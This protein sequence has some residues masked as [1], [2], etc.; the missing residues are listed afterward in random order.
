MSRGHSPQHQDEDSG[1][2]LYH[3]PETRETE[4]LVDEHRRG[5]PD[6]QADVMRLM[7]E[8]ARAS[9][10]FV[11]RSALQ[12]CRQTQDRGA[13]SDES[14]LALK[15]LADV[16][17]RQ[18]EVLGYFQTARQTGS[19]DIHVTTS[20]GLTRIEMR[21]HGDLVTVAELAEQDGEAL[22]ATIILSMCDVTE[23][24]FFPMRKQDGRVAAKFLKKVGLFGARYSHTP[25]A[26]G[27]HF[28]MR[29]INDD[30]DRV[31]SLT[32]L[33]FLP[34]QIT[35]IQRILRLP[36]GMVIL[37]G[38]TGSG[39]STTLRSFSRIWLERTGFLKRLLTVEDPPEGRVAGAIQT[40]IICDKADEA[41][42]RRAWERALSSALRLD[43]D[44][45]MPGELRD[46]I[47]ILAGIFAAQTGHLV[48]S[49]L[50]T[51]SALSIPERMITMG[52]EAGLILDA[53]LM[54]GLI[55]QRLVKTLCPHCKVPWVQKVTS[56]SDEQRRYLEKYCHEPGLCRPEDL[57]FR[58]PE[59][60][61]H[62][63][64][65][66]VLNGRTVATVGHGVTGRSVVAEVI[67][68]DARL[69][70]LLKT[71][72]K[73][74]ARRYWME[75][76]GITRRTHLLHRLGAGLV[77]PLEADETIPLEEDDVLQVPEDSVVRTAPG[78]G[79]RSD[80]RT[81]TDISALREELKE[82][83]SLAV[84]SGIEQGL[85]RGLQEALK[86]ALTALRQNAAAQRSSH[87]VNNNNGGGHGQ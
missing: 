7:S 54:V 23:V 5:Q 65:S 53:Q 70:H 2:L 28:V 60:C 72:G 26:D 43:P 15:D 31:P 17:R 68:P 39:K 62:C 35:L 63:R 78:T 11:S 40:P 52:V 85:A 73:E 61:E 20:P 10:R 59:G 12:A 13:A 1:V 64:K 27:L 67:R 87:T 37:S 77:D 55:S 3:N 50:H 46:L 80:G 41:E 82:M 24:Q 14:G 34:A 79:T 42:V 21:I 51:N 47:S 71:E 22:A 16:S 48:M 9:P 29:T 33:G 4:I 19:S 8:H 81:G 32:Q 18:A 83:V 69:F 25:T 30:G 6:V 74:V 36:E 86:V 56:L 66:V 58:H 44:A 57:Y 38:P 45:I 75:S 49:T 84:S 76:G